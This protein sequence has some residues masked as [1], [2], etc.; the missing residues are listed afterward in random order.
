M[1]GSDQPMVTGSTDLLVSAK[2]LDT[3]AW[4]AEQTGP[5]GFYCAF[6]QD[7]LDG[8]AYVRERNFQ[9]RLSGA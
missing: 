3:A 9:D 1:T 4:S 6:L 7:L 8:E 5:E 2:P